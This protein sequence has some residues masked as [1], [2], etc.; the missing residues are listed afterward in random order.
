MLVAISFAAMSCASVSYP[1][2][3]WLLSLRILVGLAFLVAALG[4]IYRRGERQAFWVAFAIFGL[5]WGLATWQ[6]PESLNTRRLIGALNSKLRTDLVAPENQTRLQTEI[7]VLEERLLEMERMTQ[8]PA[9]SPSYVRNQKQL[10]S[11]KQQLSQVATSVTR[12]EIGNV[13]LLM[14]VAF[15]GSWFGTYFYR[16]REPLRVSG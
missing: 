9:N 8:R 11:K 4:I 10:A 3:T 6:F 12:G 16:T 15:M 1:S 5:S 14:L 2:T 13:L 7:A